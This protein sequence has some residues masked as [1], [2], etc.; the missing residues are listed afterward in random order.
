MQHSDIRTTINIYGERFTDETG[1]AHS[2]VM[3]SSL[4]R[5]SERNPGGL[6]VQ[7]NRRKEWLLR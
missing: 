3:G 6:R 2:K 4:S 7:G 1:Q 5:S